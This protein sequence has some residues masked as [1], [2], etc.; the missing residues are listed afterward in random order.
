MR[1]NTMVAPGRPVD[2]DGASMDVVA[3][4]V[5]RMIGVFQEARQ[6]GAAT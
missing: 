3:R 4:T 2:L 6:A 1:N 5:S